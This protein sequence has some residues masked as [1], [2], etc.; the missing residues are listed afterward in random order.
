MNPNERKML[1]A[2]NIDTH[3][4]KLGNSNKWASKADN[5]AGETIGRPA[6]DDEKEK[7]KAK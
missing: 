6:I 7:A 2:K 5:K 3:R 4:H 1:R